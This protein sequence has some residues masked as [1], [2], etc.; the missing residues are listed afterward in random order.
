M[1]APPATFGDFL[2]AAHDEL[3]TAAAVSSSFTLSKVTPGRDVDE[4]RRALAHL[5][6][7]LSAYTGDLTEVLRKLPSE[8]LTGTT[9]WHQA[10]MQAHDALTSAGSALAV[11]D[12]ERTETGSLSS[13]AAQHL[14]AAAMSLTAGRDLLQGHFATSASG[15]R[16]CRS[17]WAVAIA[18]PE[19]T[20][21]LLAEITSLGRQAAEACETVA[22]SVTTGNA[23]ARAQ[24]QV[25]VACEWLRL[26]QARVRTASQ[27][28]PAASRGREV[29][30]AIPVN[31]LPSPHVPQ[32]AEA[33]DELCQAVTTTAQRA[34]H[35]AWDAANTDHRSAAISVTSWRQIAA[36][37]MVTS[38]NCY[39]LCQTLADR[40]AEHDPGLAE[41]LARAAD[42]ASLAREEWLDNAREFGEVTTDVRDHISPAALE[43][44]ELAHWTGKLAYADPDWTPARPPSGLRPP[45]S[46]AP[47]AT[48]V[49]R[50][51]DAIHEASRACAS[52]AVANLEQASKAVQADRV[53]IHAGSRTA[54]YNIGGR[55]I[56]MPV[57]PASGPYVTSLLA[58]CRDASEAAGRTAEAGGEIAARTGAPS[59]VLAAAK[60]LA[61]QQSE[62][63]HRKQATAGA[64]AGPRIDG[65]PFGPIE[66]KLRDC[67]VTDTRLLW[68]ASS[69]DQAG[70]QVI[71]DASTE[72]GSQ[73]QPH[74]GAASRIPH[75][76]GAVSALRSAG[77]DR[78]ILAHVE[79]EAGP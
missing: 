63:P 29:L 1:T 58:C 6:Q 75:P 68:R 25:G 49:P 28:A 66:T 78:R 40:V 50:V 20:S 8:Y 31:V 48:D 46:L 3:A 53:L 60:A 70:Q 73:R 54:R 62:L 21:G 74:V 67:G 39:V 65:Q 79:P 61:R 10:V 42:Q 14:S 2:S 64:T 55:T 23:R 33:I 38:H 13:P 27:R 12:G 56:R 57:Q 4:H 22:A 5:V 71:H 34:R 18:S 35:V 19:V 59:A 30:A 26:A 32:D 9:A 77:A 52:L 76:A 17:R 43:A 45:A 51:V 11:S 37:C 72:H 41:D 16:L 36:A 47:E 7:V 15:A 44:G 24:H 69:L